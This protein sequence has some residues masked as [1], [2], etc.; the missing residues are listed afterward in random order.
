MTLYTIQKAKFSVEVCHVGSIRLLK[1]KIEIIFHENEQ[2]LR[3]T[4]IC[5]LSI[6]ANS[7]LYNKT[8]LSEHLQDL[9]MSMDDTC[10]HCHMCRGQDITF[11]PLSLVYIS[12]SC[13]R[14]NK[15]LRIIFTMQLHKALNIQEYVYLF[16]PN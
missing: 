15:F 3:I 6:T 10:N 4:K 7:A 5:R 16:E 14:V 13:K 12:K 11:E 9:H 1:S 2:L 8:K